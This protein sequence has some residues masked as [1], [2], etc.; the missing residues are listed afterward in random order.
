MHTVTSV[1]IVL[2]FIASATKQQK[3]I[4][5]IQ[6]G[7]EIKLSVFPDDMILYVENP[8][9]SILKLLGLIQQISNM[10]GY[11]INAQ[12]PFVFLYTNNRQ[13]KEKFRNWSI[14][15]CTKKHKIVRNK[16]NQKRKG[17]VSEKLQNTSERN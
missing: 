12:K 6:I 5:G 14:Y 8:K 2:E 9:D 15:N 7:K 16:P 11:K 3:E 4:K 10:V 1:N 13:K 17:H